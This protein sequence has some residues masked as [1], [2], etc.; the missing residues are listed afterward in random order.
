ME[1]S[2]AY[3]RGSLVPK[4]LGSRVHLARYHM[5]LVLRAEN[6]KNVVGQIVVRGRSNGILTNLP[7][8][9][10]PHS[11][12]LTTGNNFYDSE[13]WDYRRAWGIPSAFPLPFTFNHGR[14][15]EDLSIPHNPESSHSDH[16]RE[17]PAL[18]RQ[19]PTEKV[20][21]DRPCPGTDPRLFYRLRALIS[22]FGLR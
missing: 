19:R 12:T 20:R 10:P 8:K 3:A 2:I 14:P 6:I 5:V 16:F 13:Q 15:A 4:I 18:F 9:V 17:H 21:G 11:K 22:E 1:W 7:A